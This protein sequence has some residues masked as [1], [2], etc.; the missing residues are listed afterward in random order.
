MYTMYMFL[1]LKEL[2]SSEIIE[3]YEHKLQAMSVRITVLLFLACLYINS[4]V[5]RVFY[6]HLLTCTYSIAV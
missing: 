6:T 5:V 4:R 1:Q 2:K 3:I